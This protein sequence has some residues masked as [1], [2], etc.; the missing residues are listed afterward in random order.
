MLLPS[1]FRVRAWIIPLCHVTALERSPMNGLIAFERIIE[2][3]RKVMG[4]AIQLQLY[5]SCYL[6][7]IKQL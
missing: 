4:L 5:S 1:Y 2:Q 7:I 6:T 3:T